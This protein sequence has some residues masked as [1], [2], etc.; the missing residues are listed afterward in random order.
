MV[1]MKPHD[2]FYRPDK[3]KNGLDLL[4]WVIFEPNLLK[5]FEK[6]LSKRERTHWFLKGYG[7]IVFFSVLLY[8]VSSA[9]MVYLDFFLKFPELVFHSG[10]PTDFLSIYLLNM[11]ITIWSEAFVLVL[12]LAGGLAGWL[13]GGMTGWIPVALAA[14]LADGLVPGL[15]LGLDGGRALGITLGL[16]AGL[17]FRMGLG[18]VVGMV[19]G[20]VVGMAFG[21]AFGL[22]RGL[23]W[24]GL[25][26][27]VDGMVDGLIGGMK[28]GMALG[29]AGGMAFNFSYFRFMF[30]PYYFF[31]GFFKTGLV[32]NPY[33]NDALIWLPLPHL[34]KKLLAQT[35][36]E[37]ELAFRFSNFLFEHRPLQLAL[38]QTIRHTATAA[39]WYHSPLDMDRFII[40]HESDD[41]GAQ[42]N[43]PSGEWFK[44]VRK[45][46]ED[47][48][49][50]EKNNH[51]HFK[52]QAWEK[53]HQTLGD[54]EQVTLIQEG[55]WKQDYLKAIRKW[56][57]ESKKKVKELDLK[58]QKSEPISTNAYRVGE[59]LKPSEFGKETFVGR[60]DLRDELELRIQTSASLPTFLLQGQR[61]VGKTSLLNFLPDL[62]GNR[63]LVL[64]EDCQGKESLGSILNLLKS[65]A[66]N[67]LNLDTAPA[68]HGDP[69][70][71]WQAF[72]T[73]FV[74]LA[75]GEDRKII[76][77]FDEYEDLHKLIRSL[78]EEGEL[79]LGAMRSFSQKQNQVVFLFTG[80]HLFADLGEPDFG[81]YFV[82]ALRLKVDYLKKEDVVKLITHPYPDFRL[83]YPQELVERMF[84]LTAGHPALLQHICSE[85]V[86]WAN[87]TNQRNVTAEALEKALHAVLDRSNEVMTRFWKD[88]CTGTLK[89]TVSRIIKQ[90]TSPHKADVIRLL[91]YGFIIE[92][93]QK[94]FYKLR[95]PLF[96]QW[97]NN[98]GE[99]FE[100]TQS[101]GGDTL[102]SS[103][104]G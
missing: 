29:L 56:L 72:E 46:K 9:L 44:T 104:L 31:R 60:E 49:V 89:E 41:S 59:S 90:G 51:L 50:A 80:L 57:T 53:F 14:G 16:A 38:A 24:V 19:D 77:A 4:R 3:P 64:S 6:T 63:F 94:E 28:Y 71:V 98:Y 102:H 30:Y 33:L 86:N 13:A 20:L 68:F 10:F 7:W 43:L 45:T 42:K 32:T 36:N 27:M 52:K 100:I 17:E 97:I 84:A 67:K 75:K 101:M 85:I 74:H 66:E 39:T 99:S 58:L 73:F 96:E 93:E 18:M 61:R 22:V 62:L 2:P 78:G 34:N 91:D 55:P 11:K 83:I 54:L 15:R 12:V 5:E 25:Y 23:Q 48:S 65:K 88:F 40:P 87:I 103:E 76:L 70:K 92:N 1:Q 35:W 21:L 69:F 47:L 82:H 26:G 37:P 8:V 81:R 79:I 95:V